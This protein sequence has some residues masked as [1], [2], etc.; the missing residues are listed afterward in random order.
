M[1]ER[2]SSKEKKPSKNEVTSLGQRAAALLGERGES[3]V[4]SVFDD[5]IYGGLETHLA[6]FMPEE[7]ILVRVGTMQDWE[8]TEPRP[9]M[10]VVV[11][12]SDSS[13]DSEA[14]T[15]IIKETTYDFTTGGFSRYGAVVN[16]AVVIYDQNGMPVSG[17][18]TAGW[19]ALRNLGF[20]K[21]PRSERRVLKQALKVDFDR[22]RYSELSSLISAC[23]PHN[24]IEIE[25][26]DDE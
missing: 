11:M 25:E 14:D 26:L 20:Q 3:E 13:E 9:D 2:I 12:E 19:V 21:M 4:S 16:E 23:G 6:F 24:R 10:H 1:T 18:Q 8:G 22:Q 15:V 7:D 5:P 17:V